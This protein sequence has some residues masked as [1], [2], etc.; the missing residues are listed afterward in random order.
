MLVSSALLRW[1]PEPDL[2]VSLSWRCLASV[3]HCFSFFAVILSYC[4]NIDYTQRCGSWPYFW[5]LR[6]GTPSLYL[7]GWQKTS[8][9]AL[10][11]HITTIDS[12][13]LKNGFGPCTS[14]TVL[15]SRLAYFSYVSFDQKLYNRVIQCFNVLTHEQGARETQGKRGSE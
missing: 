1:G 12:S 9:R 14:Y 11:Q 13:S 5:P 4:L 3:L 10:Q 2:K 7:T 8:N 15:D 6:L